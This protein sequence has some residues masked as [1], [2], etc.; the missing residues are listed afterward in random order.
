MEMNSVIPSGYPAKND[1]A[2]N[3]DAVCLQVTKG[4]STNPSPT[5]LRSEYANMQR[6]GEESDDEEKDDLPENYANR[7]KVSTKKAK[8]QTSEYGILQ[9]EEE[10]PQEN[11]WTNNYANRPQRPPAGQSP[12]GMF[13]APPDSDLPEDSYGRV[14]KDDAHKLEQGEVLPDELTS[15]S[16]AA[17]SPQGSPVKMSNV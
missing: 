14:P 17:P 5:K 15:A 4:K 11:G 3:D 13:A 16:S 6:D 2:E 9:R 7:R 1:D 12:Y 10:E 8:S